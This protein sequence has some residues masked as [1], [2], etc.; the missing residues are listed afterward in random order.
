[1]ARRDSFESD[2]D[3]VRPYTQRR[4]I[5]LVAKSKEQEVLKIMRN[6]RDQG[7]YF[8]F[9]ITVR[10]RVIPCHRCVVASCSDFFRT[11]FA[12]DM[13]ERDDGN[14]NIR[15][16]STAAVEAF[17]DYAYTAKAEVTEENVDMLFKVSSFFQVED[18]L[19]DCSD[20]LAKTIDINNC[21][22]YLSLSESYGSS[23][24]YDQALEFCMEHFME[25]T[26][27]TDFVELN[28]EVLEKYLRHDNLNIPEED[29]A[30]SAA[31][32]WVKHNLGERERYLP[33]LLSKLRLHHISPIALQELLHSE[34]QLL[35]ST[36]CF[37]TVK[38]A[39]KCSEQDVGL[40]TDARV[41]TTEKYLF[42]H[43]TEDDGETRHTFC[44]ALKSDKWLELSEMN[45]V[46]L[47]GSS[48]SG[49]GEKIFI[50]GGCKGNCSRS[51]RLHVEKPYHD[52]TDQ[53][54]CYC[55]ATKASTL[56]P[57]MKTP[58]TMH[59][60][61]VALKQIFVIGGK[62]KGVQ[63]NTGLRD[64]EAYNPLKKEW[65]QVSSMPKEVYFQEVCVCGNLIYVLGS[66][67]EIPES[68]SPSLDY[69]FRYNTETDQ[70]CELLCQF[71]DYFFA[72]LIKAVP[73][74]NKLYVCDL[75][76][77]KVYKYCIENETWREEQS[78]ECAGFNAA[79]VGIDDKIYMLGGDYSP[80]TSSDEVQVYHTKRSVWEE[81]SS[82]P[83]SLTEF[84]CE[85]LQFN[86]C[87]DPWGSSSL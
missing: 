64:V 5:N 17:L 75:S 22:Q 35:K 46:D 53:T 84:Y 24:L 3:R 15:N 23:H 11:M 59:S 36:D 33:R 76:T 58:R 32:S 50:I 56:V 77:Y 70:W 20:F 39:V 4:V 10:R 48:F 28:I 74:R 87:R 26:Q 47:P 6:F 31:L 30:L 78:L 19:K 37:S 27:T 12:V 73:G 51:L 16:F 44:Y 86:K 34:E 83:H 57:A 9:N 69:F 71:G 25:L 60:S 79:A 68:F 62:P 67:E 45:I 82:M 49:Y 63:N 43:K 65:K 18:L 66:E 52:A 54:W 80:D 8:D 42:V 72:T 55:P 81:V 29:C 14:V 2:L 61:V 21:L 13:K 38:D 41:S 40:L 85:L 7:L 1:M